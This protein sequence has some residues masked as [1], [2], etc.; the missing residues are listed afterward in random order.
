[1]SARTNWKAIL[2][3]SAIGVVIITLIAAFTRL[4]VITAIPIGFLFG[5]FLQKGDLCG[6]SA[7]SEVLLMK[8][9]RK[10]AGL[11]ILI[12]TAMIGFALLDWL[13]L[14]RLNPKPFLYL[15]YIVGGVLFGTGMVLAGGC[16]SG[17]LYKAAEGNMNS[18]AALVTIPAGVM[19]VDFGPLNPLHKAMNRFVLSSEE[20]GTVTLST[21]SGLPYWILALLFAAVTIIAV[22]LKRG[23]TAPAHLKTVPE[24]WLERAVRR[25]WKPWVSGLAIGL[26]MAPAY[27]SSA[28]TGR[29]Y[30]LGV[31]HGV[32]QAGL[33]LVDRDVQHVWRAN[34]AP[35]APSRRQI[36]WWLVL[37]S[38]A[39]PLG[40]WLSARMNGPV[41]LMPKP[42]DELLIALAGGFLTGAGAAF[43]TGC[44]VGNIMSGWALMSVGMILFGVVTV[45]ANWVATYFYLL[46]GQAPGISRK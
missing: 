20:G 9:S 12:V 18:I 4:W 27:L 41:R 34:P 7:F 10:L 24:P 21:I 17:C 40:S 14:V 31:T 37:V 35:A 3:I 45:L 23:K 22:L 36:S 43:A 42:P 32:M 19:A 1:M 11:W 38:L 5:F 6:A 30:P 15:N 26:L 28:A 44:V 25:P 46:G 13:G 33:L 39:L 8:D 2:T 29:N 16:I